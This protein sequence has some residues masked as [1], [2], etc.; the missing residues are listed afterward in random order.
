MQQHIHMLRCLC[1]VMD[2][3]V[4]EARKYAVKAHEMRHAQH[5]QTADWYADMARGHLGF[6]SQ[7]HSMTE[8]LMAELKNA[9]PAYVSDEV[10][11]MFAE[12]IADVKRETAEVQ[13]MLDAYH[14]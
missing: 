10:L 7:G 14:K 1:K 9:E 13:T 12:C 11:A 3:N 5:K 2:G 8:R 4:Q 6:N